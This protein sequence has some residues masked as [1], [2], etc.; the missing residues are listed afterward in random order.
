MLQERI[1]L[2]FAPYQ[3]AALTTVLL[4]QWY[5]QVDSNHRPFPCQG[6]ALPLRY[7]DITEFIRLH[8]LRSLEVLC[9]KIL[10][11]EVGLEPTGN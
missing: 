2:S 8:I 10:V 3:G 4:E 5:P 1:E 6:N 9:K 11:G 7:A